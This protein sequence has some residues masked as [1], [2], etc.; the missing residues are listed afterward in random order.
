VVSNVEARAQNSLGKSGQAHEGTPFPTPGVEGLT[1]DRVSGSTSHIALVAILAR[2][3][4][5]YALLATS[6][7][8]CWS[9]GLEWHKQGRGNCSFLGSTLNSPDVKK[10]GLD[11][12]YPPLQETAIFSWS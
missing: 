5:L 12:C 8:N 2:T 4:G 6:L 10:Y 1:L 7:S 11:Y 3:V 9:Q